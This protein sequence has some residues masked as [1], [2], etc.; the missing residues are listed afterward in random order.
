MTLDPLSILTIIA[1]IFLILIIVIIEGFYLYNLRSRELDN[2]LSKIQK[3]IFLRH[4]FMPF[5]IETYRDYAPNDPEIAK[6][7]EIRDKAR[8]IKTMPGWNS[9]LETEITRSLKRN[10]FQTPAKSLHFKKDIRFLEIKK[11]F[12]EITNLINEM[13][14]DYNNLVRKFNYKK[15]NPLYLVISLLLGIPKKEAVSFKT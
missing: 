11:E 4:D 5:L 7:I 14:K 10:F 6:I 15:L 2:Y 8:K 3:L 13:A 12:S 9:Q 1:G